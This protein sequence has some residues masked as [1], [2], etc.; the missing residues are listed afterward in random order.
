MHAYAYTCIREHL[1][2]RFQMAICTLCIC[3]CVWECVCACVCMCAHTYTYTFTHSW[4]HVARSRVSAFRPSRTVLEI[5]IRDDTAPAPVCI[6]PYVL[7]AREGVCVCVC[8]H[9]HMNYQF[10]DIAKNSFPRGP[11]I[12]I[13]CWSASTQAKAEHGE[14]ACT[15]VQT[16]K[17]KIPKSWYIYPWLCSHPQTHRHVHACSCQP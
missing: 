12:A 3:A 9:V 1:V 8:L 14:Q 16:D 6:I 5:P 15:L 17:V 7:R 2:L 10:K 13:L 11:G 4:A